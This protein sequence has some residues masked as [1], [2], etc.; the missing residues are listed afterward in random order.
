VVGLGGEPKEAIQSV[1]LQELLRLRTQPCN[2][3]AL[4]VPTRLSERQQQ[5][6]DRGAVE[7][8]AIG[9]INGE[10]P[11]LEVGEALE[12]GAQG[13]HARAGQ[14]AENAN[15]GAFQAISAVSQQPAHASSTGLRFTR[16]R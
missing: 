1:Q 8:G 13:F 6:G 9:E 16:A 5:Q 2:G 4:P 15:G 3:E 10:V 14:G 7:A 12:K 11:R